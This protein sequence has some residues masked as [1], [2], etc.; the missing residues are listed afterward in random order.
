VI[1][2][3]PWCQYHCRASVCVQP[4][5]S[6]ERALPALHPLLRSCKP[7]CRQRGGGSQRFPPSPRLWRTPRKVGQAELQLCRSRCARRGSR[8][9]R[10]PQGSRWRWCR[11]TRAGGS[12]AVPLAGRAPPCCLLP[13]PGAAVTGAGFGARRS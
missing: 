7:A 6:V 12:L 8:P 9:Q 1:P 4:S 11:E 10:C 3:H 13:C 2:P 5:V